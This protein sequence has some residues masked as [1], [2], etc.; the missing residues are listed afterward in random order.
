MSALLEFN[1]VK[2]PFV[3]VLYLSGNQIRIKLQKGF[4]LP[5]AF[6]SLLVCFVL[7]VFIRVNIGHVKI[8]CSACKIYGAQ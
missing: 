3:K 7:W 4:Y 1:F 5:F 6:N 2:L 8:I